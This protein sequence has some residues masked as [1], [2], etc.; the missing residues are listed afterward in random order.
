MPAAPLPA[1]P[2]GTTRELFALAWP[3]MFSNLAYTAVGFTDT[4]VMG[5]LGVT[6]V[7]AVGFASLCLLTLLLLFRGTVNGAATFVAR[8]L[9]AGDAAGVRRWANVFLG[10][11][12]VGLPLALLGG[13]LVD[14]LF[15]LLRPDPSVQD[16]ARTYAH[17]RVWEFPL[18][19]LGSA[20]LSVMLGLGNTRTPMLLAWLVVLLNA[21]LALL[22]VF[23]LKWGV[24]GAA[25]AAVIAV[26]VQNGLAFVLLRRLHGPAHG[27]FRPVRPRRTELGP[28]ARVALPMGLTELGE[29]GAFTAFQGV[30]SRLGPI[31][32]AASQI[33]NQLA[34]LGFLPAFALSS[35]T[36]SLLSR[37]LGAGHPDAAT[38]IGWRG[39]GLAA[40][41]MG[42]LGLLFLIAPRALIG[43]FNSDPRVLEVGT[44]VLAVM[45]AFQVLDGVAIV[46][47]GALGG[48]GDTRFR[49]AVTLT[50][51]WLV[52][53]V[54]AGL[55][56]PRFGVQGAW[57]AALGYIASAAVAYTWRF[58]S[59]RWRRRAPIF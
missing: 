34:S 31:E 30:L 44:A 23:V 8:A 12:L 55:L 11:S 24:A 7:G 3:L 40:V 38:R 28:V 16:I 22:F 9:G 19:L 53:V 18:V 42:L 35:A 26:G 54:G 29:V 46:L 49:L 32:L 52:M 47:G 1:A 5:R 27:S 14:G 45:A 51:S 4:L 56:A 58:G 39:A 6:E 57:F 17:V 50:G 10:L 15:A 41:L 36:G 43:L 59:G 13:P 2:Q 33:A 21:A 20:S 37:A 48:A 25:W